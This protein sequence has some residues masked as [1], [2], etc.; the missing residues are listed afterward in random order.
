MSI[1]I[2]Q[3]LLEDRHGRMTD[4]KMCLG[5]FTESN[6]I[7]DDMLTLAQY[8]MKGKPEVTNSAFAN[9]VELWA[10]AALFI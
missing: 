4:L 3:K 7:E 8:G 5:S 2:M 1:L 9:F 6:E 10:S